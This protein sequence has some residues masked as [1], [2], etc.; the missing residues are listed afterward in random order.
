MASTTRTGTFPDVPVGITA[1]MLCEPS[2]PV[3][4]FAAEEELA[5]PQ[6][7]PAPRT[8]CD[9]SLRSCVV[10]TPD[11]ISESKGGPEK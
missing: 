9:L 6:Q 3:L 2:R 1:T 10:K 7:P 4:T 5:G 11:L 8:D